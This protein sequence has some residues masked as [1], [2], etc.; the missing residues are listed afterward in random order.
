MG[1]LIRW[2]GFNQE[3]DNLG[4]FDHLLVECPTHFKTL[5]QK[6]DRKFPDILEFLHMKRGEGDGS[7]RLLSGV[8]SSNTDHVIHRSDRVC[9]LA[10]ESILVIPET[11]NTVG[12]S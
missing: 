12:V 8:E 6:D 7:N 4:P 10:T 9:V 1:L 11:K 5:P 2:F 3:F